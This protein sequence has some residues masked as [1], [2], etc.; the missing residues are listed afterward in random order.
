MTTQIARDDAQPPPVHIGLLWHSANSGNLGVGALTVG[1]IAL[2]RR[3]AAQAGRTPHFTI[4]GFAD[5][6]RP[7]YLPDTDVAVAEIDGRALLPG[8]GFARA[9][10]HCDLVCDIGG[11][12][13][14][15]DIYAGK[16]FA[17]LWLTK[18]MVLARRIPLIFSPQTIGPFTRQPYRWLAARALAGARMVFTRDPESTAAARALVPGMRVDHAVDVAFAMPFERARLGDGVVHIGVNV[19]GLLFNGGY[20]GGNFGLEIDYPAYCRALIGALLARPGVRVHLICHVNT[21]SV[22]VDDDGRVADALAAEFPGA[23]RVPDFAGPMAAKSYIA[24]LDAL[25]AARMHACIAAYSSGV[26]VIP[27]AYSRKFS[28][29]FGGTLGYPHMVPVTG[30]PTAAA[31]AYTLERIDARA[32]LSAQIAEGNRSVGALLDGYVAAIARILNSSLKRQDD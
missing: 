14:F 1:N 26:A 29:L 11:G 6:G 3:A 8:G 28:G 7:R 10:S 25:V 32:T 12:D 18:M 31:V 2:L 30:M 23:V 22:P 16:R 27:V 24:G 9:L 20:D 15:A 5:A 21:T 17:Y 4:L 19:S 13:S